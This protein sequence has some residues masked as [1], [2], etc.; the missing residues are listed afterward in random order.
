MCNRC[1][2]WHNCKFD[3]SNGNGWWV[4]HPFIH[5]C[6]IVSHLMYE[7]LYSPNK[8]CLTRKGAE[9]FYWYLTYVVRIT[10]VSFLWLLRNN[11]NNC[12]HELVLLV[13]DKWECVSHMKRTWEC[14]TMSEVRTRKTI[15]SI[16]NQFQTFCRRIDLNWSKIPIENV[17][18]LLKWSMG[19]FLWNARSMMLI[20]ASFSCELRKFNTF[21][22]FSII[23]TNTY[24]WWL[25]ERFITRMSWACSLFGEKCI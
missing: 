1:I 20:N 11:N 9:Q 16:K 14:F 17:R 18:E 15:L 21:H 23:T 6:A 13:S 12:T 2:F 5:L 25:N 7:K 3:I 24:S 19:S 22:R 4:P 8:C 10:I